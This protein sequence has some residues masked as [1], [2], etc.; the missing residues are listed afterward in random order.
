MLVTEKI[1]ALINAYSNWKSISVN[2]SIL[3]AAMVVAIFTTFAKLIFFVKELAIA[4]QFGTSDVLDAFLVAYIVPAFIINL[5]SGSFN[6]A[7][8]P[9]YIQVRDDEGYLPANR[10]YAGIMTIGGGFL[11]ICS[12]LTVFLSRY[13]LPFIAS[14][15]D[16][17]KLELTQQLLYFISP[18]IVLSGVNTLRSAISNA[19]EKF[20]IPSLI[21]CVTPLTTIF[22]L[23]IYGNIYSLV[24]GMIIGQVIEFFFFG[25]F[26]KKLG[27]SKTFVPFA[28]DK[29][30]REVISQFLP[31]LAGA[32]LIN[33]NFLVDQAMAASLSAGNVAILNYGNKVVSF[34]LQIVTSAISTAV[35]P[36][37]STMFARGDIQNAYRLLIRY[38]KLLFLFSVPFTLLFVFFSEAIV[39]LL[40]ERGAFTMQDTKLVAAVQSFGALQIPFYLGVLLLVRMISAMRENRIVMGIALVCAVVNI[41]A[42]YILMQFYGVIGIS[43]STSLVY[44]FSF[45]MLFFAVSNIFNKKYSSTK[46]TTE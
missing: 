31:M 30:S 46:E 17:K 21:P 23:V 2:R 34:P 24:F 13:Y 32:F 12:V 40:L 16:P 9:V 25:M 1:R 19:G 22:L 45:F 42:N 14:G 33:S 39:K 15:F 20:A 27:I 6:A 11:L 18:V 29:N 10:L 38:L 41:I 37:F 35:L 8:I 28:M 36:Y 26:L 7:L 44:F 5:T 3:S 43:L 4:W